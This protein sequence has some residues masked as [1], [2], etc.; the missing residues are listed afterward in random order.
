MQQMPPIK[1]T[2]GEGFAVEDQ[3]V[4]WLACHMLAGIPWPTAQGGELRALKC[5]MR[6]DGWIFDDVVAK[7]SRDGSDF[8]VACSIKSYSVFSQK[9]APPD[10]VVTLW[11]QWRSGDSSFHPGRDR[12][13]LFA[14]RH[15]HRISETWKSLLDDARSMEEGT[16]ARRITNGAEP[17]KNKCVA[18][19]SVQR[20]NSPDAQ[21]SADSREAGEE[22]AR[23]LASFTLQ[24]H[25]FD[26]GESQSVKEA[27]MLCQL[28]LADEAREKAEDLWEVV[29]MFASEI[30]RKGGDI[31]L[32]KLL[33]RLAHRFPLKQHPWYAADWESIQ[34]VSTDRINT[35]ADK[36]GGLATIERSALHESISAE[37]ESHQC[38]VLLGGSGYGKTVLART[39]ATTGPAALSVWIRSSDLT[40][41]GGLSSL[42]SIRH[43]IADILANAGRPIRVV[44]DGLDQCFDDLA[45]GEAALV[46]QAASHPDARNRCQILLTCQ[47]NDW[48][49]V[50]GK[51][52]SRGVPVDFGTVSVP[53]ISKWELEQVANQ[54]PTLRPLVQRSHLRS[55]LRWPKVL[56]IIVTYWRGGSSSEAWTTESDFAHWFWQFA[57]AREEQISLRAKVVQRIAVTTA[58]RFT[59]G[60]P[61]DEFSSEESTALRELDREEH[62][63]MDKF[64]Q[65]V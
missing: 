15:T 21:T 23:L 31:D 18:F 2:A 51:L 57:I 32:P 62:I 5:Q 33:H 19:K 59:A 20:P 7:I 3:V 9:G 38:V 46:L 45:F 16:L 54:I 43:S 48:A 13:A 35:V 58:D 26:H 28:A 27:I 29:H 25:D 50:R 24:E 36:I 30:R 47:P 12:L 10:F 42:W 53:E 1:N 22:T 4:A 41:S 6:Q 63:T 39:W 44:L 40:A 60:V 52:I 34:R 17:S 11:K 65:T 49:W 61:L 14:A 8:C 64:K 37:M 56:D 55:L